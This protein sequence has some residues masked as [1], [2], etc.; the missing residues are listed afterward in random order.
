MLNATETSQYFLDSSNHSSFQKDESPERARPP[1]ASHTKRVM[2][3]DDEVLIA[4]SLVEILRLEGHQAIAVSNGEAAI[5][6][7]EF[8]QPDAIICDVAM[9]GM[10]GF[11][12]AKSVRELLPNCRMILFSGH[13]S[14][15]K[16]LANTPIEDNCFEFVPKPVKPEVI[17]R[18]LRD[19]C[20]LT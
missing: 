2:V 5:K 8:L 1:R 17:L 6:W 13:A 11:E 19:D 4:E 7:A 12:V 3:V 10:D 18:M 16:A 9:P 15:Q 20:K 14:I